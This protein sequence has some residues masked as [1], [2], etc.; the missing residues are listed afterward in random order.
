MK[1]Y[2]ALRKEVEAR[3]EE[4]WKLEKFALGGAAAI[5]AWL[6]T[7]PVTTVLAWWLPFIFLTG[8][9]VR[10]G[11]GM[12]HLAFRAAK[13]LSDVEKEYLKGKPG[14]EGWFRKQ[15]VNETIAYA[16]MWGVM[17]LLAF[18][19]AIFQPTESRL[20][21]EQPKQQAAVATRPMGSGTSLFSAS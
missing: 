19:A 10:F 1:E 7:H 16:I 13:Y 5:A 11:S 20:P 14:Y 4:L 12:Y 9:A 6:V 18:L 3:L 17:L 8:C 2:E 15:K 21:H